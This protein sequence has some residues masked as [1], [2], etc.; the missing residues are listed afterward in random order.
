MSSFFLAAATLWQRELVR[1]WRQKSRVLGVV[2]SPLVF[3]LLMGYG[4]GDLARFYSGPST[5]ARPSVTNCPP[6]RGVG[7]RGA[8]NALAATVSPPSLLGDD[9]IGVLSAGRLA[10][11][12]PC[13]GSF[14]DETDATGRA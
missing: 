8:H 9:A 7:P 2:A 12:T 4:S 13:V 14:Q 10:R 1:F 3:W 6:T 5:P 11:H